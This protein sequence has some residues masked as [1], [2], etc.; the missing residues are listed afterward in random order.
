MRITELMLV[1]AMSSLNITFPW[2]MWIL[3]ILDICVRIADDH[4]EWLKEKQ[5]ALIL[6]N[7]ELE[8]KKAKLE[9]ENKVLETKYK[10][11][12]E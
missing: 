10:G 3:A 9:E 2:W 4:K 5:S 11:T 6:E 7:K 1:G 8:A 12:P